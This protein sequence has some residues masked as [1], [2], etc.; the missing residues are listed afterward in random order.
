MNFVSMLATIGY[1]TL[2]REEIMN[3][4]K[5][6]EIVELLAQRKGLTFSELMRK[7]GMKNGVLAYHL[8]MLEKNKYVKSARDGKYRRFFLWEDPMPFYDS[9]ERKIVKMVGKEPKISHDQLTSGI[10]ANKIYLKKIIGKMVHE[11]TLV[12]KCFGGDSHLIL[13]PSSPAHA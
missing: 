1:T 10:H 13:N 8:R 7:L 9:I 6:Q 2:S 12:E 11:G 4:K 3:N 5:R